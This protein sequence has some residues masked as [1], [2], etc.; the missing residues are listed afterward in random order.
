[1][2]GFGQ[3]GGNSLG[4]SAEAP[5]PFLRWVERVMEVQR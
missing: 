2:T 5:S 1:M 3:S 4:N